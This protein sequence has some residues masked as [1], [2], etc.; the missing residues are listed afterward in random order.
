MSP[1]NPVPGATVIEDRIVRDTFHSSL[2]LAE[3]ILK[4]LGIGALQSRQTVET[5]RDH[6]TA[7][8]IAQHG[9]AHD[10]DR[11]IEETRHWTRE[12]EEMFAEDERESTEPRL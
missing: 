3:G 5:F 12:L 8:L 4:A 1:D 6:D 2:E 9:I 7:R 11:M 10:T